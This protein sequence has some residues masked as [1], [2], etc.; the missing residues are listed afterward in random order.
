MEHRSLRN[1]PAV[2]QS[3][4]EVLGEVPHRVYTET[5]PYAAGVPAKQRVSQAADDQVCHSQDCNA[6]V[7]AVQQSE[8]STVHYDRHPQRIVHVD[9]LIH[10]GPAPELLRSALK[11]HAYERVYHQ[12]YLRRGETKVELDVPVK[13]C[14][15]YA[16]EIGQ[17]A[18]QYS[19]AQHL[20]AAPVA[21][22]SDDP[23]HE[24]VLFYQKAHH[25]EKQARRKQW[26][27][28]LIDK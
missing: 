25:N 22:R 7:E 24:T 27:V 6:R 23:D 8:N 13:Q 15:E 9:P 3:E 12:R 19:K 11:K 18:E 20:H 17:E 4:K 2:R 16:E 10:E 1:K 5:R 21:R 28:E 14:T 26:R